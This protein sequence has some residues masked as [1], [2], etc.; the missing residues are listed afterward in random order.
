MSL[1]E[2]QDNKWEVQSAKP[3]IVTPGSIGMLIMMAGFTLFFVAVII[4]SVVGS[5][6]DT[7]EMNFDKK[8]QDESSAEAKPE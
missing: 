4:G 5:F 1:A 6:T 8:Q 7:K 2:I 3:P